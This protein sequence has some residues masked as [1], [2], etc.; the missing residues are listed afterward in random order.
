MRH[1]APC[2]R[3]GQCVRVCVCARAVAVQSRPSDFTALP[4]WSSLDMSKI[5]RRSIPHDP[6]KPAP[7]LILSQMARKKEE[8][9][10]RSNRQHGF[11]DPPSPTSGSGGGGRHRRPATGAWRCRNPPAAPGERGAEMGDMS[12]FLQERLAFGIRADRP[13]FCPTT[14]DGRGAKGS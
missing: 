14:D 2:F 4:P 3:T 10:A 12:W 8:Q 5:R 13:T 9:Q 1:A 7:A 6:P 11:G